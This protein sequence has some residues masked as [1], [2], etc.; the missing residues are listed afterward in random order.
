MF[1]STDDSLLQP[2]FLQPHS[3]CFWLQEL[4]TR[5]AAHFLLPF[6]AELSEASEHVAFNGKETSCHEIV[7]GSGLKWKKP[8]HFD[9]F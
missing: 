9:F 3:S 8:T 5:R 7:W 6:L 2:E 1:Y 4:F